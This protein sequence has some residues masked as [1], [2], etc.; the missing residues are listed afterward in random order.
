MHLIIILSLILVGFTCILHSIGITGC[1]YINEDRAL[2]NL[3]CDFTNKSKD[4]CFQSLYHSFQRTR[5]LD[6][7][8]YL[9]TGDCRSEHLDI[10]LFETFTNLY[11]F[12]CPFHGVE[13]LP[14]LEWKSLQKLNASHNKI[15]KLNQL[16]FSKLTII[17]DID[18]SFNRIVTIENATFSQL[19]ILKV[20]NLS[21][22]LINIL[23]HNVFDQNTNLNVLRLEN[24]PIK[25]IDESL[26]L[27][28]MRFDLV[29]IPCDDVEELDTSCL[30]DSLQVD[31]NRTDQIIFRTTTKHL[32]LQCNK[33]NI[34]NLNYLNISGNKLQNAEQLIDLLGSSIKVLDISLNFIDNL[35][36][37]TLQRWTNLQTLNL[38]RNKLDHLNLE[39]FQYQQK[40]QLLDISYNRLKEVKLNLSSFGDRLKFLELR[41][42][43]LK[44]NQ[45][46]ELNS[47]QRSYFPK[48][49][50]MNVSKN[51]FPRHY[52]AN[53]KR[54]WKHSNHSHKSHGAN[55]KSVKYRNE[56]PKTTENA[57]VAEATESQSIESETLPT[58]EIMTVDSLTEVISHDST[59]S[60]FSEMETTTQ[61]DNSIES[62]IVRDYEQNRRIK[63]RY[64]NPSENTTKRHFEYFGSSIPKHP[65]REW[66]FLMLALLIF[67]WD[68]TCDKI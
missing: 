44:G 67:M 14:P 12:S 66:K 63:F 45:L 53:F 56:V 5:N 28:W 2:V 46:T 13:S 17:T 61:T 35:N 62:T 36:V 24:N 29:A 23:H 54:Q 38:S 41:K 8:K 32:E 51:H 34:Q 50:D 26:L 10:E 42:L 15:T 52:M 3:I 37:N 11:E 7:V 48:L 30:K 47:I 43:D 59:I 4:G 16:I 49:S 20:I 60:T 65:S 64:Q 33:M 9:Q 58:L 57:V 1:N 39:I 25:R 31:L 22:N 55:S 21:N 6:A 18:L 19:N 40:L 68:W 27:L